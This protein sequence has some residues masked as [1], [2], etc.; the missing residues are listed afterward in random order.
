MKKNKEPIKKKITEILTE[1]NR[2]MSIRA[3]S[4][5]L[6]IKGIDASQAIVLESLKELEKEKKVVEEKTKEKK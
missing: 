5:A 2:P 6:F 1:E 3:L 4:G